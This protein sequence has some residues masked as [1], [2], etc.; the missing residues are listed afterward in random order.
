MIVTVCPTELTADE[1][2]FALQASSSMSFMP[3]P[4]TLAHFAISALGIYSNNYEVCVP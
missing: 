2:L 1:T 4:M 3:I